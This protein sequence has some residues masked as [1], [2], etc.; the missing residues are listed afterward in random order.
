MVAGSGVGDDYRCEECQKTEVPCGGFVPLGKYWILNHYQGKEAFLGWLVLQPRRHVM[1]LGDLT[2]HEAKALGPN[3]QRIDEA[4]RR[5][6]QST[7]GT[8]DP[9]ERV[10]VVYFFE[11]AYDWPPPNYHLHIHLIA[12]PRSFRGL[13]SCGSPL[14]GWRVHDVKTHP[15]FPVWYRPIEGS[16]NHLMAALRAALAVSE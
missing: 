14:V 4:L 10:Y 11:S 12:R 3:I 5:Y 16:V 13:Q 8:D 7:F 2:E 6:W 1:E 15:S 9:L